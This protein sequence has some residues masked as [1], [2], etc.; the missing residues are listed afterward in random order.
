MFGRRFAWFFEGFWVGGFRCLC[1]DLRQ[2][3]G[4]KEV[5]HPDSEPAKVRKS[6]D[7]VTGQVRVGQM[8]FVKIFEV[9]AA[10]CC[11]KMNIIWYPFTHEV[12]AKI[13]NARCV[14]IHLASFYFK[15]W[16][17]PHCFLQNQTT[18]DLTSCPDLVAV[19]ANIVRYG[20]LIF[21]SSQFLHLNRRDMG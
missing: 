10:S 2:A 1:F 15:R 9:V 13:S 12:R 5:V 18:I 17:K 11:L 16:N 3:R 7:P 19:E 6:E 14:S 4:R 8:L 21:M 20:L